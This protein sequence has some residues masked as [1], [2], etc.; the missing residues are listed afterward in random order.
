M[1]Q[2]KGKVVAITGACGVGVDACV[3]TDGLSLERL[4]VILALFGEKQCRMLQ[5]EASAVFLMALR[6]VGPF[7]LTLTERMGLGLWRLR[8]VLT[9]LQ[10]ALFSVTG[11]YGL[12]PG[13]L[14]TTDK[15]NF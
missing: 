1:N 4:S 2:K 12:Q 8:C 14:K 3:E 9:S 10:L 13:Q 15:L 6:M 5:P 7:S 11:C